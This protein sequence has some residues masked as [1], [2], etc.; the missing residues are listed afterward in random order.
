M[1]SFQYIEETASE[2]VKMSKFCIGL[3]HTITLPSSIVTG[4]TM[5]TWLATSDI[6]HGSLK[7]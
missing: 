7:S 1:R 2:P 3:D 4:I 5:T 6:T